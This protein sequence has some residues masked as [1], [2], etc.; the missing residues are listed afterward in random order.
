M[1]YDA[2]KAKDMMSRA[3]FDLDTFQLLVNCGAQVANTSGRVPDEGTVSEA[4]QAYLSGKAVV[5][6]K[7]N[8][9]RTKL[10]GEDNPLLTG[11]AQF[12]QVNEI[13]ELP[14]ALKAA[15]KR[16]KNSESFSMEVMPHV[17]ASL[18]R[19]EEV[20][21]NVQKSRDQ[22]TLAEVIIRLYGSAKMH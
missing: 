8:D 15:T 9:P 21:A 5:N 19:G 17:A 2:K 7:D 22:D 3:I 1:G 20:W 10:G 14:A 16:N 12:H 18:R 13:E 6:F 11:L 4:A